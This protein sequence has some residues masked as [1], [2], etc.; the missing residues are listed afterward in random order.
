MRNI[1]LWLSVLVAEV[2]PL[3]GGTP[4]GM[5]RLRSWHC[6]LVVVVL[7]VWVQGSLV[8]CGLGL[9]ELLVKDLIED[10]F[11]IFDFGVLLGCPD[12]FALITVL[13]FEGRPMSALQDHV[14]LLFVN[15]GDLVR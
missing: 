7:A 14:Y 15:V 11:A 13:W 12:V 3:G 4:E 5:G 8:L 2:E 6:L 1:V 10:I 9:G